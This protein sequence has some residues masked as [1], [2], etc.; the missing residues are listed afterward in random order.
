MQDIV[1]HFWCHI[2]DFLRVHCALMVVAKNKT[3][4]LQIDNWFQIKNLIM[5]TS[6]KLFENNVHIVNSELLK[7]KNIDQ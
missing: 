2:V 3:L 6:P 4:N 1:A 5:E 7:F